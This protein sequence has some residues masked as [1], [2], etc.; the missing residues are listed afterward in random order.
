MSYGRHAAKLEKSTTI[1]IPGPA[2]WVAKIGKMGLADE[3]V[4][5]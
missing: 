4:G 3:A 2:F 5:M 1:C